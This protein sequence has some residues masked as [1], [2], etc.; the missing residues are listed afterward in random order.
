MD[1]TALMLPLQQ[2]YKKRKNVNRRFTDLD[3]IYA[4]LCSSL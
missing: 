3:Y 2:Q 4:D 1:L